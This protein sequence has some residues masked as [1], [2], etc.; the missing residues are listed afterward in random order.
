MKHFASASLVLLLAGA[1]AEAQSRDRVYSRPQLP[2]QAA[3]DRLNLKMAW[4]AYVPADGQRDRVFAAQVLADQLLVL[5]RSGQL[6]ALDPETGTRQ[7]SVQVGHPYWISQ[8]PGHNRK[9]IFVFSGPRLYSLDRK[10]GGLEWEM[11]TK[12][13]PAAPVGADDRNI[14]LAVGTG[15][16]SVFE[17]PRP[18]KPDTDLSA[19]DAAKMPEAQTSPERAPVASGS[20]AGDENAAAVAGVLSHLGKKR[21]V[22]E[23]PVGPAHLWDYGVNGRLEQ[24]PILAENF[25]VLA[26]TQGSFVSMTKNL[27]EIQYQFRAETGISA[28]LNQHGTTAYIASREYNVFAL[29]VIGGNILWRFTAD[30][31]IL[32]QPAVTDEDV[33]VAPERGGL[34]RIDRMMGT[35][36]WRNRTAERFVAC[37]K[38]FVYALDPAGRLLVLDRARGTLLAAFDVRDFVV[39]V[40]N[41]TTDRIY[42]AGNNGLFVCL[43]DRNYRKPMRVRTIEETKPAPD[44]QKNAK[45]GAVDRGENK[46]PDKEPLEKKIDKQDEKKPEPA[47]K[48]DEKKEGTKPADKTDEKKPEKEK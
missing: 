20:R 1:I 37:N 44:E 2:A 7:W 46:K 29:D 34:Y 32:R 33:Y 9:S 41:E 35:E 42:L 25:L 3:L 11:E 8:A 28:P 39:P 13:F 17:L 10:T 27:H 48:K 47:E 23:A 43:H 6:T 14:Y 26:D 36:V 12:Y 40:V 30:R 19:A 4:L 24:T 31:P 16:L 5:M 21:F 15:L 22:Q 38:A 45:P 18:P